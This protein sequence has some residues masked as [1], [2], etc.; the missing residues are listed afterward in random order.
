MRRR[1]SRGAAFVAVTTVVLASV[2]APVRAETQAGSPPGPL[3]VKTAADA[4]L[5]KLDPKLEA[6]VKKGET[7]PVAV[8]ATVQGDPAA[9]TA[10]LDNARVAGSGDSG[11]VLGSIPVQALPKL[12]AA[13]GVV[14][15][16]PVELGKTGQ[17]LN[18]PDPELHKAPTQAEKQAARAKL[19]TSEVPYDKAPAPRGSNFEKLR[20]QNLL[21]AKTHDF[22]GAW[23]AGITGQGIT[24]GVLDGGTDFGHPDLLNT[25][26]TWTGQTG[27]KAGWNGWPK[28]FDPYGT[29]QWLSAP[30]QVDDGLSW[31]TKTTASACLKAG[32]T[33][34]VDFATKTGPSRNFSAPAGTVQHTYD[35]PA[36]WSK[37]GTVKVGSHP[38]DYLLQLYGER[39][40]YL[41]T[42]PHTAGVY[43]TVYVDLDDDHSFADEKPVTK[44][45]P[46][47]YRDM[48]GDG[49]TDLS[50]GLLYFISDGKTEVP[51]GQDAFGIHDTSY[52]SGDLLAWTGDFDP[53]IEGHGTLTA[54]NIVGQAVI[55]GKAP[56]F[57]D[58]PGGKYA[59]AVLGGAP[60]AKL[61][62]FGDI[63][64]GFDFSTQFGYLLSTRQ[65]VDVTSNSYGQSTVDNDGWDAASQEADVIHE[66][67]TTT[68][69]FS[70]G[71]GAPGFG[72]TG[73][74]PTA[75]IAVGASTQFGGTGWDSIVRTKQI[76]DNDVVEWSNRGFQSNAANG[77]DVVADGAY[78]PGDA[79]LNT[80]L[81]GREAWTTW[82]GTSRSTPVAAGATALIYQ[83]YEKA[84]GAK[85]PAGFY[86]TAKDILKTS[87]KDL[88]YDANVQG[89]GS[90]DAGKAVASAAGRRAVVSP[91]EWRVG[92]YRGTE[93]P[94]FANVIAPGGTD[95]QKFN[96]KGPGVWQ[97]SDRQLVRTAN[98]TFS[99]TSKDLSQ[100][101]TG[102]FNAPDYLLDLTSRV[103]KHRDADLMLIKVEYP[104]SEFDGDKNLT[105]DQGWRLLTYNWTD[106]NHDGKLWTDKNHNGVVNHTDKTTSSNIDGFL[107]LD[108][109]KSEMQQGEY[110]RF[111]Y[112]RAGANA[113]QSLV[114]DP[115]SR[116]ANGL[117]L[118]LQHSA[119]NAAIPVTHFKIS[120]DWYKNSDWKWVTTPRYTTGSFT[121][122]IKVPAKT[123]YGMYSG[124][125][126]LNRGSDSMVVPVSVA[127]AAKAAQDASGKL[128]GATTFG[129][130]DVARAQQ[131]YTYN[132]GSVFGAN[133][134]TWRAESG[135]WRFFYL[136]VPKAPAEGTKFL[137]NTSWNDAGPATDLDTLIMGRSQ[138]HFQVVPDSVWG[139]PYTLN[140]VGKSPN[141]NVRAGVWRFDTATGGPADVVTAPAQE[142]LQAFA[143][144][145]VGW[146]GDKFNTPFKVD[147]GSA[148]V[149][150]SSVAQTATS[151]SGG[152][153]VKFESSVALDGLKASAFGLSQPSTTTETAHQDNADDP[154]ASS[155]KR[156]LTLSHASR[157]SVSTA[158]AGNDLDLYVVRDANNDGVFSASEIV[159]SSAGGTANESVDLISPPD[160][161]Y[162]IWVHGFA[163]AGTP[164]FTFNVNAVQG[165]DLT[166]SGLPTGAVPAGT[167]VTLH[168]NY[169]KA[170]T[171]GQTYTGELLLGPTTAP[172]ALS[173][174][175]KITR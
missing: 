141:T 24:V 154:S 81:D 73:S 46:A 50:G 22:T 92:D 20:K 57:K 135:D 126:V 29:L 137:V 162:Q 32:S 156:N 44:A 173:V 163:V 30:T 42:D 33:C 27:T 8:F 31:Y 95:S 117:F 83:A 28:A 47:S 25:W 152:F 36:S 112:H 127:V 64:L 13:K 138:N 78:S 170:M 79:T 139:A 11:L 143:V 70:T 150:P 144:H 76:M 98:D 103:K 56:T 96:V 169:N 41:V 148:S 133:D 26:Q 4:L 5:A 128:T 90:I 58:I 122:S 100:E 142:G 60:H 110:S 77:V 84:H 88:G 104:R 105:E 23:N 175:I 38:D 3:Q 118:G 35:F 55:N 51:G 52:G 18:D 40:A 119:K 168:V 69:L 89:S 71:N 124:A 7:A 107:D 131:N 9:A 123:P 164:S 39:P 85:L 158:M 43:D 12:A 49:Y 161:N 48:N 153:D 109:A 134:W 66:G 65:G 94:A 114:R 93:Y 86:S 2:T 37:S 146:E 149:S 167:P 155:F 17:P 63:Y 68:P 106:V 75:G 108:F 130:E 174:P 172:S 136:D 34:S 132:N 16:R 120:I 147:V 91:S 115:A 45:S 145:Q 87:S 74:S 80:I 113:L 151:D 125:V 157:L 121:A 99:F 166:V 116:M 101:S 14:S 140:T 165:N 62:P 171:V 111:M 102:N 72:T 61:A 53:Q 160:G 82:G 6:K 129:G 97:V 19:T 1:L 21:D 54:S 59:G 67:R 159:A 10:V 15:V